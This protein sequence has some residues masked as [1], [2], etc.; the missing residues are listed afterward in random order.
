[1]SQ[2]KQ[3]SEE[4][5]PNDDNPME[6]LFEPATN[7]KPPLAIIFNARTHRL[8]KYDPAATEKED[9][10]KGET[11]EQ[12]NHHYKKITNN[13]AFV[14]SAGNKERVLLY[15]CGKHFGEVSKLDPKI[16]ELPDIS[17]ELKQEVA[18]AVA[19]AKDQAEIQKKATA[20][21]L[22]AGNQPLPPPPVQPCTEDHKKILSEALDTARELK[23][24]DKDLILLISGRKYSVEAI[25]DDLENGLGSSAISDANTSPG[26]F[27]NA[28]N[29]VEFDLKMSNLIPDEAS[30]IISG[31]PRTLTSSLLNF[32]KAIAVVQIDEECKNEFP[33]DQIEN[34]ELYK[35]SL[36]LLELQSKIKEAYQDL[37][38]K[39]SESSVSQKLLLPFSKANAVITTDISV[40]DT[41][42][43]FLSPKVTTFSGTSSTEGGEK[44][45][46]ATAKMASAGQDVKDPKDNQSTLAK[47]QDPDPINLNSDKF[48]PDASPSLWRKL[49]VHFLATGGLL[50]QTGHQETYALQ[51]LDTRTITTTTTKVTPASGSAY[52]TISAATSTGTVKYPYLQTNNNLAFGALLGVT[53]F[54][55]SRDTFGSGS[56]R[57]YGAS[58]WDSFS[59][60]LR[61]LGM[62]FGTT[63][64]QSGTF[65][66]ALAYEP[67]SG[68][69]LYGGFSNLNSN[70]LN[71]GVVP[72][73]SI[74]A[75]STVTTTTQLP[76]Q[77]D[78]DG[79]KTDI[80]ISTATTSPCNNSNATS[81]SSDNAPTGSTSKLTPAFGILL[82]QNIVDSIISL[83]KK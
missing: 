23:L 48:A 62:F 72:C 39:Y 80:L 16:I 66:L 24:V 51:T 60:P 78:K 11:P 53:Y 63:V 57:R 77:V 9:K 79:N 15:I 28:V 8:W 10:K 6:G 1:M 50:V 58:S 37:N 22:A 82:N 5:C 27:K 65:T 81:I 75:G 73:Y 30:Q 46:T 7:V 36:A 34:A 31:T 45:D 71:L 70:K 68:I 17:P 18:D 40:D 19:N 12:W 25:R 52:T 14:A 44:P 4:V 43:S 38:K 55:I 69:E 74:G 47:T 76:Q 32:R 56:Q 29:R 54:P 42:P 64:N 83:F 35:L 49:M 21:A 3:Q 20:S 33:I 2:A 13:L 59:N 41:F 26:A 67:V 61:N